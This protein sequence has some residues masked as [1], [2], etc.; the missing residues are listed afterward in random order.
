MEYFSASCLLL[1]LILAYMMLV[2]AAFMFWITYRTLDTSLSRLGYVLI[3]TSSVH[4]HLKIVFLSVCICACE[5]EKIPILLGDHFHELG[6]KILKWYYFMTL[7]QRLSLW[8]FWILGK[9]LQTRV[10]NFN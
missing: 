5:L 3:S 9:N 1:L 8:L 6:G 10:I 7:S 4:F 2:L